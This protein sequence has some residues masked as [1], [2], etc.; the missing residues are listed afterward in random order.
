[1]SIEAE[2]RTHLI[3]A[4]AISSLVGNRVYPGVR[5]EEEGLPALTYTMIFDD[6]HMDLDGVN[7]GLRQVRV[8]IDM[9]AK[10]YAVV[11]SLEAAVKARMNTAATNFKSVQLGTMLD[12][13]EPETRLYRRT[14]EFSV[15]Y[16]F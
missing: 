7:G 2:I 1:M 11:L 14:R 10:T 13:F 4:S 8:Q 16:S 9:W 3:S 5:K 15:W 12:D 6:P